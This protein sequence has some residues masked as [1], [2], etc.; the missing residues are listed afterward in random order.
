LLS[1]GF[2]S[3]MMGIVWEHYASDKSSIYSVW[4][5]TTFALSVNSYQGVSSHPSFWYVWIL[6]SSIKSNSL[7]L[8]IRPVNHFSSDV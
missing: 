2:F 3:V 7:N 8:S 4:S 1:S 6:I 5:N